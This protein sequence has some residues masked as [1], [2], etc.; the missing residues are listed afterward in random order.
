MIGPELNL[1][2][3]FVAGLLTVLSPCV[4]PLL[5]I[6][7]TTARSRSAFGP[8]AL[9]LGLA[10][11]FTLAGLLVAVLGFALGVDAEAFRM[12]GGVVMIGLG[13]ILAVAPLQTWIAATGARLTSGGH[14]ALAR[15]DGG[16][17]PA[18]AALGALLGLVWTPCVG[19]TLGAAVLLAAQGR[20]LSMVGLTM[21]V[22]GVGAALPLVGFGLVSRPLLNRIKGRLGALG[23]H[24]KLVLG[25]LFL[26]VGLGV[27]TGLDRVLEAWLVQASPDWLT[28]LTTRF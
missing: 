3:A 22:F 9:G 17:W 1:G 10:V 15:L 14:G 16:G 4:L 25:L 19:P 8:V 20:D 21:L 2:L 23:R 12:A 26:A 7:F 11:S 5:P 24:G 13:L 6:V 27:V 28:T 18:H